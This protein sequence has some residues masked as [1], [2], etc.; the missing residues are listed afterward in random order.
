M[1]QGD[2][3]GDLFVYSL[4]YILLPFIKQFHGIVELKRTCYN[5]QTKK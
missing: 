2:L 4:V 3:Q 5:E 1:K